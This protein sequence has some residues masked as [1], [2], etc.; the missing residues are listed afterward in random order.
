MLTYGVTY[1]WQVLSKYHSCESTPGPVQTFMLRYLPDLIINNVQIPYSAYT[2]QNIDITWEVKNQ[3]LGNTMHQQWND[4]LYM[5]IDTINDEFYSLGGVP[6]M[7]YLEPGQSYS[8]KASFTLPKY[9][10]G[11]F[12]IFS[13]ADRNNNLLETND[14]N[15]Q[16]RNANPL[17]IKLTP[18]PD[19]YVNSI[20]TPSDFFSED[21]IKVGWTVINKGKWQTETNAWPD[22]VYISQDFNNAQKYIIGTFSHTGDTLYPGQSYSTVHP[23]V[24]PEAIFGKYYIYV[25]TDI[26]NNVYEHAYDGNNVSQSDS[27]NKLRPPADLMVDHIVIPKSV[28]NIE[29]ANIK[30]RVTNIG[31]SS[32]SDKDWTDGIYLTKSRN[33]DLSNAYFFPFHRSKSTGIPIDFMYNNDENIK[34]PDLIEP[35]DYYV[36]VKT[37]VGN[38]VFEYLYEK[39]N[40]LRSDTTL[41]ILIAPWPDLQVTALTIPDSAGACEAIQ[42]NYTVTNKGTANAKGEWMDRIYVS[43]YY[44]GCPGR[45]LLKEIKRNSTLQPDSLYTVSTTVNLPTGF[46]QGSNRY[47]FSVYTDANNTIYEHTTETNN[48]RIK[49]I[50]IKPSDL[51]VTTTNVPSQ[52]YS[53]SVIGITWDIKNMGDASS[54]AV[55]WRDKIEVVDSL[56]NSLTDPNENM[57]WKYGPVKQGITYTNQNNILIPDGIFGNYYIRV[58]T[59]L[60]NENRERITGNNVKLIPIKI[61]LRQP[62]DLIVSSFNLPANGI[63]GQPVT[64]QWNVQNT[65]P[66]ATLAQGWTDRIYLSQDT[67]IDINDILLGT[68]PRSGGLTSGG[69][70]SQSEQVFLPISA[71]GN[72]QIIVMTDF[73]TPYNPYGEEYEY[74]AEENNTS[75]SLMTITLAPPSDLV[76]TQVTAPANATTGEPVTIGWTVRNLGPNKAEGYMTDM[77]YFSKDS[78]WD[79][80]DPFFGENPVYISLLP[81]EER[82]FSLTTELNGTAADNYYVV[83]RTD[84]RNNIYEVNDLNNTHSSSSRVRV[85]VPQLPLYVLKQKT[86]QNNKGI[87]YRIEIPDSLNDETLLIT[88]KGDSVRGNNELYIS[89]DS[90]PDRSNY[91]Y[92]SSGKP[93]YGNQE[94]IVPSLKK[95]RYYLL[96]YGNVSSGATQNI[97]LYA[98][99]IHF[100]VRSVQAKEGGNKGKVTIEVGGARFT[101]DMK[102]SLQTSTKVIPADSLIFVDATKVFATFNLL[103]APLGFYDV[104]AIKTNGDTAILKNG[105]KVVEKSP[106]T[107]VTSVKAPAS[108]RLGTIGII[109]VQFANDGNEDILTPAFKLISE[110]GLPISILKQNLGKGQ[111]QLEFECREVNGPQNVLRPG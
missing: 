34:I 28:T 102:L 27:V 24:I 103:D 30:W 40:I 59:D 96:V 71:V 50:F 111:T 109:T 76:I 22:R 29:S 41:K 58:T 54:P 31:N 51:A 97:S 63:A 57:Y 95:G 33:Y 73:T 104:V 83:V 81:N 21:T 62:T 110:D 56:F 52:A 44:Y 60:Y 26:Y 36:Y 90:V 3:G 12:N 86:L 15:N 42:V 1:K 91:D 94:V 43:T 66:G 92:A 2:G 47:C 17:W 64:M 89:F 25:E 106:F 20:V 13:W 39:N 84:N 67:I 53:G 6:N 65:G 61:I 5:S 14:N 7:T 68:Y 49:N 100:Q 69:S 55:Y 79:I 4:Q 93:F 9:K 101:K 8:K 11:L 75:M 99:I 18:P 78:V 45:T 23:V 32:P 37:D 16:G 48:E 107:L 105:F 108:M 10:D 87:Y 74:K 35:G 70:Y 85:E 38:D 82:T 98:Q 77:V 46:D 88:L 19:L 80:G 72:Y